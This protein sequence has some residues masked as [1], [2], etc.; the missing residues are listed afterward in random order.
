MTSKIEAS[1]VPEHGS[2]FSAELANLGP[3][4]VFVKA[5]S[6][7]EFREAVTLRFSG[8]TVH[9]EVAFV[10]L[11]PPGAVVVF[12]A[13]AEATNVIEDL[14]DDAEV[15]VGADAP[16]PQSTSQPDGWNDTTAHAEELDHEDPTNPALAKPSDVPVHVEEHIYD[17]SETSE[18]AEVRRAYARSK[19]PPSMETEQVSPDVIRQASKNITQ[20]ME[21]GAEGEST[22]VPEARARARTV[23]AE[24][25]TDHGLDALAEDSHE[26]PAEVEASDFEESTNFS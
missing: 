18:E 8:V 1:V 7:L 19:I 9:G 15:V 13:T 17:V 24:V 6:G 26:T 12:S 20:D 11:N 2:E 22:L 5:A 16:R 14:M 25:E 21:P 23:L 10:C 4:S 3:Q